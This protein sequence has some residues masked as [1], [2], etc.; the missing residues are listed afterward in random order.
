MTPLDRAV[1]AATDEA[2]TLALHDLLAGTELFLALDAEPVGDAISPMVVEAEGAAFILAFDRP[3][4][5]TDFTGGP[6]PYAAMTGRT[7]VATLT[8]QGVALNLGTK[9]ETLLSPDQVAWLR[10]TLGVAPVQDA[11]RI[12][13][14]S[15]PSGLPEA[16]VA[17]LDR[18]LAGAAGLARAAW[19]SAVRY[20]GGAASH[21]V[22][23]VD[24]AEGAEAP[25]AQAVAEALTFSGLEAGA[26]DVTF[27]RAADPAAAHLARVG[28]RFDLPEATRPARPPAPPGMDGPPKLR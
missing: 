14:L 20:E 18:K 17:A 27:L 26:L 6:T 4:R 25:L 28:L 9:G 21:L 24:A 12:E 3:E 13:E 23:F 8:G 22:A 5:L 19:L 15:A 2:G 10:D 1:A 7:L 16:L 11:A